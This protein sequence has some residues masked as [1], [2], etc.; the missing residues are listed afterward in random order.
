MGLRG[1]QNLQ[2]V[3]C[4]LLLSTTVHISMHIFIRSRYKYMNIVRVPLLCELL[5]NESIH[6][7][8]KKLN[9][10]DVVLGLWGDLCV[11]S[12]EEESN[13]GW[14]KQTMQSAHCFSS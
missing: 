10:C 2:L 4:T 7:L 12:G 14:T 1:H 13:K 9:F 3:G 11:R 6:L 5:E 8:S